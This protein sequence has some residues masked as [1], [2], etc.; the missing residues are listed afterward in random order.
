MEEDLFG[1]VALPPAALLPELPRLEDRELE[2]EAPGA[3]HLLADDRLG[4]AVRPEAERGER[5]DARGDPA[6]HARPGEEHVGHRIGVA[7]HLADCL[8]EVIGPA[9]AGRRDYQR[10]L[11]NREPGAVARQSF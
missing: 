2:L 9:H 8:Q 4:L 11:R 3:V 1:R 6:D 7:R 5:V 10:V